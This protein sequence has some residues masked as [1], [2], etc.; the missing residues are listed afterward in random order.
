VNNIDPIS[1]ELELIQRL[2]DLSKAYKDQ[3]ELFF[4]RRR[5][6]R[7]IR[8]VELEYEAVNRWSALLAVE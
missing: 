8:A 2:Y 3:A 7:R 6:W 4:G 5:E 1:R